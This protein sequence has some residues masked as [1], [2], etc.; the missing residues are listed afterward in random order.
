MES[1]PMNYDVIIIGSGPGGYSAAVRAGQYG[2]KTA[3]IEKDLK[4]GGTCLH[5]GCIPTKALLHTAEVWER[6]LHSDAEGIHCENPRLNYP[7]VIDRKNG[8][9]TKHAKG[10][11]YLMKKNKVDWIKG[12]GRYAGPGKVEVIADGVTQII[13]TKNIVLATGSEARML[14]G[15]KP[16]A[17]RILTNVEILN[18]TEV[19]KSLAILGAGAV[20][21]E[22]ASCFHRFGSKVSIFEML[23][24][25]VPVEDEEVSKELT[26]VFKKSGIRIETGARAEHVEHTENGVRFQVTLADGSIEMVEA[27][28]LLVAVGRKPNTENLGLEGTKV[29]LDR[30]FIKVDG[31]Q[32]TREPGVY[33]IGDIVAGTPQLAHV[34]TAEG[35]IAIGH[36]AG[37]EVTP[38]RKNRIPGATYT[39]PGIGSVGM[40]EA[41]AR[42]KGYKVLIGKFPFVA[43]SKASILGQHD[44]FVKIVADETYGEIL[45]V[46]IIGP[47][48]YELIGEGVLAMEAEATV[49]TLINTIHAHPTIYE[50][51]GEAFNAV[52]GQ[53]I[54]A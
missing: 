16:D 42:A 48:A 10:V 2:L 20:G 24:R 21:V 33:A 44:G 23:P 11:E 49:D 5:V 38:I 8:I 39:E 22:F 25:I 50:A 53:A 45:G 7:K 29:E 54:N 35:M 6:F 4:L 30:G 28:A 13:E 36:I 17:K 32:R 19:P 1:Y 14:P 40:T 27:E 37:Q 41:E 52:Y 51:L 31:Y 26:R 18:L 47:Q 34:A 43:N 3:L 15:L 9:V 46:H 12:Y